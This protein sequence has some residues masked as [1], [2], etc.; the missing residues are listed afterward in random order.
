MVRRVRSSRSASAN[1]PAVHAAGQIRTQTSQ[2]KLG[3]S[4]EPKAKQ[5]VRR[6]EAL[7][8]AEFLAGRLQ[9]TLPLGMGLAAR[10]VRLLT[11]LLLSLLCLKASE[12][13]A[14]RWASIQE[15]AVFTINQ[16][17]HTGFTVALKE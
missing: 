11:Q 5:T 14:A 3:R 10:F 1:A 8:G 12:R 13:R 16:K 4:A 2:E 6:A 9:P 17:R 7:G 15:G